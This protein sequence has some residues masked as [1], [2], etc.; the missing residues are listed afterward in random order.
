MEGTASQRACYEQLIVVKQHHHQSPKNGSKHLNKC[1][2][3]DGAGV[4]GVK[5]AREVTLKIFA[6]LSRQ[7]TSLQYNAW[8]FWTPHFWGSA[9][10]FYVVFIQLAKNAASLDHQLSIVIIQMVW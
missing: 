9:Q 10:T 7:V 1:S 3:A 5:G 2:A 8:Q 4:R 6:P